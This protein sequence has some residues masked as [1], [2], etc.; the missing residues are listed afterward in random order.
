MGSVVADS[1]GMCPDP[2]S[3][4]VTPT[5]VDGKVAGGRRGRTCAPMH[6]ILLRQR[7]VRIAAMNPRDSEQW[8]LPGLAP[9]AVEFWLCLAAA[10]TMIRRLINEPATATA[11]QPDPPPDGCADHQLPVAVR[12]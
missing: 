12:R 5:E 10:F 8:R 9:P 3:H 4:P 11:G 2:W 6:R 7:L 1:R